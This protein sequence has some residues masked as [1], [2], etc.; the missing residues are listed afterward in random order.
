MNKL[1]NDLNQFTG[2]EQYHRFSSLS[3]LVMTDGV[4][5]LC[6]KAGSYWLMD[7]ISSYQHK[8]NQDDMLREFQVWTLKVKDGKG[9]VTCNRDKN[10]TAFT[11]KIP[12]TDFPMNEIKLY[13]INGVIMLTSEY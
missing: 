10:D 9:I 5:Y 6:D 8:C 12:Y 4:K 7:V 2:T 1:E 3:K 11:Q 13:C